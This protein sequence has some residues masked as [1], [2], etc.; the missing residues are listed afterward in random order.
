MKRRHWLR[1]VL[2]ASILA[3]PLL[4]GCGD[5]TDRVRT[6]SDSDYRVRFPIRLVDGGEILAL[7]PGPDWPDAADRARLDAFVALWRA[8][9]H[10]PLV[11]GQD[12][13]GAHAE[14]LRVAHA[15]GGLGVGR[16]ET[17]TF[18]QGDAPAALLVAFRSLKTAVAGDCTPGGEDLG[19]IGLSD[20]GYDNLPPK[21]L[22]CAY[23][24][25]FAAQ[26]AHPLDLVRPVAETP[27]DISR[28]LTV[29]DKWRK[30]ETIP[31]P[32]DSTKDIA[33]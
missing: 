22:G 33:K 27:P 17:R 26:I 11:I 12:E 10:G 21:G 4:A 6:E 16:I 30:G 7:E 1:P 18:A 32:V 3:A 2:L 28:R 14:R 19:Q 24:K 15:L 31:V 9:G 29:I 5:L 25:A 23:Q 8:R 13:T 20:R